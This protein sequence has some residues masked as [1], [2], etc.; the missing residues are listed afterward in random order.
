[1][2]FM[3]NHGLDVGFHAVSEAVHWV[4]TGGSEEE[5]G[6]DLIPTIEFLVKEK[7]MPVNVQVGS[8]GSPL[9]CLQKAVAGI[10]P[11]LQ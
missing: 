4:V 3:V 2:R 11:Q 8:A 7:G 5:D 1:M 9:T 6:H 10:V